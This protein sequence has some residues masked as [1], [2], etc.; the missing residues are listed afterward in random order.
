MNRTT[1]C[2]MS[3]GS[4]SVDDSLLHRY[5]TIPCTSRASR[6]KRAQWRRYQSSWSWVMC[7]NLSCS[8]HTETSDTQSLNF[9][10]VPQWICISSEEENADETNARMFFSIERAFPW[11]SH[12]TVHGWSWIVPHP[13]TRIPT[14]IVIM[15]WWLSEYSGDLYMTHFL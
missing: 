13:H 1:V 10:Q 14:V 11:H 5:Q 9:Q 2:N 4:G 6:I 3:T 12:A 15:C 8:N 7:E